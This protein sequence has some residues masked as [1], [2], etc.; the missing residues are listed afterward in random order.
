MRSATMWV[1]FAA[2]CINLGSCCCVLQRFGVVLRRPAVIWCPFSRECARKRPLKRRM[3]CI[4]A[5]DSEHILATALSA[6]RKKQNGGGATRDSESSR[7]DLSGNAPGNRRNT[8]R[9][10][11]INLHTRP[12]QSH[13]RAINPHTC[14]VRGYSWTAE[15]PQQVQTCPAGCLAE[16]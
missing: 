12:L 14:S 10:Q 4:C 1:R 13:V 5:A 2:F 9:F 11:D 6:A 15:A 8:C 16:Q 7:R 3:M